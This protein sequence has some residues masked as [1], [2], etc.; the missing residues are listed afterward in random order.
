MSGRSSLVARLFWTIV[1][2]GACAF[3]FGLPALAATG[4][5]VVL[6]LLHRLDRPGRFRRRV[7][8]LARRHARTLALRRR[9]ECFVD[10]YGNLIDDGWLR[11]RTY[12]VERTILPQL[13]ADGFSAE[14]DARWDEMLAIVDAVSAAIRL[15][16]ETEAPKDGIAYERFCAERLRA[17]GWEAHA[18]R[19]S[20]DQ[21]ADVVAERDGLR[22]VLQCK[23]YAKPVGNAAVQEVAAAARYWSADAAAV[24]STAGFTP[25]AR[26]LAR[27]TGVLLLHHDGLSDLASPAS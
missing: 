4:L 3:W 19:A 21:G 5:V 12:F 7:R 27:A 20:G 9:Q 11:E 2:G 6:I 10:A 14:A 22:L 1:L 17:A 8:G 23:R 24:V 18:T 13:D 26:R 16:E 15:P 25:A